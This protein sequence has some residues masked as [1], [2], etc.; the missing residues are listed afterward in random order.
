[1]ECGAILLACLSVPTL[2]YGVMVRFLRCFSDLSFSFLG[3][4]KA[5]DVRLFIPWEGRMFFLHSFLQSLALREGYHVFRMDV[6][7]LWNLL[8]FGIWARGYGVVLDWN[9][10]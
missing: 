7:W 8:G 9:L 1:M 6:M 2:H 5:E 3:L 10:T 4:F